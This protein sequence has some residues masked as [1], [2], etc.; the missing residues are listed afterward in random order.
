M[1][2]VLATPFGNEK[3]ELCV[4]HTSYSDLEC[5]LSQIS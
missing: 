3:D 5:E 2:L 1:T 4:I